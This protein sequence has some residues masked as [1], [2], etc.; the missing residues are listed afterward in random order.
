MRAIVIAPIALA[1]FT[2]PLWFADS[3][4]FAGEVVRHM[5]DSYFVLFLNTLGGQFGCFI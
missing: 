3:R 1:L 5:V 4:S 2:V